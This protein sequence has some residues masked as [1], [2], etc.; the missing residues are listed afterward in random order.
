MASETSGDATTGEPDPGY[1]SSLHQAFSTLGEK[2]PQHPNGHLSGNGVKTDKLRCVLNTWERPAGT[3]GSLGSPGRAGTLGFLPEVVGRNPAFP[4]RSPTED[5][6]EPPA[7]AA[8]LPDFKHCPFLETAGVFIS[9]KVGH[10][11]IQ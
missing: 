6:A 1:R 4:G 10:S 7:T 8:F 2:E 11:H 5:L 3:A 9:F